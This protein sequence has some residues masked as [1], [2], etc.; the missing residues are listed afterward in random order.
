MGKQAN[1]FNKLIRFVPWIFA[2]FVIVLCV[3]QYT[4]YPC[5]VAITVTDPPYNA[6]HH[7]V[8]DVEYDITKA[9]Y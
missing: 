2:V 1:R 3:S 6:I 4:V 8:I 9:E 5:M 7:T